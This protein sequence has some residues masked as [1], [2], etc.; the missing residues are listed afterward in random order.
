VSNRTLSLVLVAGLA[1]I[2]VWLW[3]MS[4]STADTPPEAQPAAVVETPQLDPPQNLPPEPVVVAAPPAPPPVA[5]DPQL[6]VHTAV[7]DMAG[8]LRAGDFASFVARYMPPEERAMM[9][10]VGP[11]ALV[12]MAQQMAQ[13]NVPGTREYQET[14]QM[15]QV[16]DSVK[17]MEPTLNDTGDEATYP[18][19]VSGMPDRIRFIRVDG[20]WYF[21]G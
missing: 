14:Q 2:G 4:V 1:A 18:A 7:A 10:Q 12:Q 9:A 11:E 17:N 6:D 3:R 15:L 8:L 5:A 21:K 20:R 19:N 16:L 13:A